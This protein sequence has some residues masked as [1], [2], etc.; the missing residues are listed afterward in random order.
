MYKFAA[1]AM[2]AIG[3]ACVVCAFVFWGIATWTPDTDLSGRSG[4]FGFVLILAALIIGLP[5][6]FMVADLDE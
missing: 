3:I 1:Y 4:M 6:F 5:G 2:S